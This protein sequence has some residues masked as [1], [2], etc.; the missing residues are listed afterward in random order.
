MGSRQREC[1]TPSQPPNPT[2][3]SW[4]SPARYTLRTKHTNTYNTPRSPICTPHAARNTLISTIRTT[5]EA[6]P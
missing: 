2:I 3:H 4:R 6:T 1:T 5:E